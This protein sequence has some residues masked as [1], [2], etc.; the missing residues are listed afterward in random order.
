MSLIDVKRIV[1]AQ[2]A[3]TLSHVP[4]GM[5]AFI[6]AELARQ[7]RPV[8]YVV[9]DGQ[10]LQN[11]E[12]TLSFAAPDIPVLSL[13][14]WDCLPYDRVSPSADVSAR[15]LSALS[16]LISLYLNPHPAI[17]LVTVNAMLQ[18]VAPADVIDSL[19]FS[20]KPGN[21][22]RM[23][24]IAARL[25]RN[26]FDRVAT[27]RE[28]GEFAVRGGI[29][30]V[31][32]PGAEEPVRL[33]FFG[34]TLESI[35]SFD[36]ANQRTIAQV[37]SLDLNP[38]SEVTLTPESISRFRKNYLSLFGAATRDDA[39]YAAVSEGRRYAGMEHWL[40]MFYDKLETTFD[41]LRGFR[42]VTDHTV[43]EAAEERAKLIRDYYEA[44]LNSATPGKGHLAQ[45]T[46]YKPVPPERLY[47]AAGEFGKAL[48][49]FDPIRITP[50]AE[51]R[52]DSRLVV[53]IDARPTPRWAKSANEAS[54]EGNRTNVFGQAVSYIADK[55]ATGA[56]VI[57]SGWSE[58]SLD[59]LLQ[60][61][62]EH[63]LER[64]VP[65]S[66]LKDVQTLKK[67]EAGTAVLSLEGGF[68]TR[69]L[70]IVG[71]Q[72]ILGDRM[73]R[74]SKRRKRAAD[75]ISEA[76]GLD[77]GAVVVHAE[78][79]IGRFVGLR[80]IEAAG[81][82][83]ACLE[84][85]YA[86]DAKLFLP[87]E[88]ID[89]LSRY[90]G[91][92]TEVQLDKLGGGAWQMRKAKLKKRLLDMA[93]ALI[94]I[95]AERMTRTA[96]VLTT[97][98]G[99]YDE[100]AARFPYDETEDQMNAIEQVR[101]DL[102]QGR[103]MDRLVC[104][105]V[106]FGKT[107]VALRAAFIAAMNGIQVAVVV[108][109][110]LLARQHFKTF[111]ER[112]RGL[113]IRV[114]QASRLVGT[115]ELNLVKKEVAE[116]KT[117]IVVGT[118]ALLGS[119]V[120]FA[121]LGLLII[122]E[123]QHFGV[124]HKER[125]KDLKSDVHVLT[126]SATPIPRTLQLA[127]TGV[128]ELSLIT[129]PPVDRMAVRTFI[130][131]FDPLV[132]RETLMREHY[133]GGQSFYVCPRLADLADIKSF[134]DENVPELKV[135]VAHGQMGAGELE[136]IM[137]AFYEGRYDVLLS[138]TIVE[139]GLDVP[140]ANTLIVHRADMF[141][142]AQLYQI[143]GRVGR[144]KVR[145]FAL[146]TLPVNKVLTAGA[147]R[148]LKVLQSLDT[149]GAGFQL[150]SHDLD[151]RG[152]GNLLGEEQSGHIKEVGFE[153]YQQMLEE[154]VA[155]VKGV[156]EVHDTGW[157]PQIQV[158]T[159]VM[160]PDNYVPDLHLRLGL[161]RRLGEITELADIDA[162][163]A[164]M[165]DR[166]GPMPVEVQHLLKV[167]YIKAL[168]RKANVEKLEAG[169]KGVV[170]QFRGKQFPNPAALVGYIAKQGTMAKIRPDHSVF[171]TRDLPTPDKRLSGAAVVMTQLAELAKG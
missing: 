109:T 93:G 128:R 24:D 38:M 57:V 68:E 53:E 8:A 163:G 102:G 129:T 30:D 2:S 146:L 166:F 66:S 125:L 29:L 89:L 82:P 140:T 142:L 131:P 23:D 92:A 147:E 143:R 168:C 126:L 72:D 85:Q 113:P 162:F 161:Y 78:H 69:D 97:Q 81:A 152:A 83:H 63:G 58:G 157:S 15:R 80:T 88:N 134:L 36:P 111:S 11:I 165:I 117:D 137:N 18:K 9:S 127:M 114:Q 119:G 4:D 171:L 75:F 42:M 133:R 121:N 130:S 103:P 49:A 51:A 107:E 26:G 132:I 20:A 108:P 25:E 118:H 45:G 10:R 120:S 164:E 112:F 77:E 73:V 115:K 28:V 13:P 159:S 31:F 67:G 91:E 6:L 47:L 16:G 138:T 60:V 62:N 170:V 1:E 153:L 76:A 14:A 21:Q 41:Y 101:S 56:K 98:E 32:V 148:R 149:L 94:R 136:D 70:V 35:R 158:G 79:G 144:S 22:V 156:D 84:L 5:D 155:E 27:V 96:P 37:R 154:A 64:L 54:E 124:K 39:L 100:F 71:E 86:D 48:D 17:V 65:I 104:G 19:G 116:G 3:L 167:V 46:P 87:V 44:R 74:R 7:G 160:I 59:R 141:G 33:D 34:D 150:A 106:G 151:I 99:F 40:P 90:G 123:E 61:L 169:P 105:D 43:R 12:Q 55:R 122:D 145:A 50:F 139:S 52:G 135:A 95:A 110:T